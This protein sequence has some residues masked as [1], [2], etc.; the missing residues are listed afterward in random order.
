MHLKNKGAVRIMTYITYITMKH[1]CNDYAIFPEFLTWFAVTYFCFPVFLAGKH[2][3]RNMALT[4]SLK[5][6][7]FAKKE[8]LRNQILKKRLQKQTNGQ[9]SKSGLP[10][11]QKLP[12]FK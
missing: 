1:L 11:A 5:W 7:S 2:W 10:L 6:G 3:G 4:A 12:I 8:L 9:K